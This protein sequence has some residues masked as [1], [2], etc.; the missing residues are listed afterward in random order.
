MN[1]F[2]RRIRPLSDLIAEINEM[3]QPLR[4]L[5]N[6]GASCRSANMAF[7]AHYIRIPGQG[8]CFL[9]K[10][11]EGHSGS[12]S[13]CLGS[14][15]IELT[16]LIGKGIE[17]TDRPRLRKVYAAVLENPL[18]S[19]AER[20]SAL[21]GLSLLNRPLVNNKLITSMRLLIG[22]QL[23]ARRNIINARFDD[24]G[25]IAVPNIEPNAAC[26]VRVRYGQILAMEI[27]H[28]LHV[29]PITSLAPLVLNSTER[30]WRLTTQ[31]T[32]LSGEPCLKVMITAD[33]TLGLSTS[34]LFI[35]AVAKGANPHY[36]I[37]PFNASAEAVLPQLDFEGYDLR[38]ALAPSTSPGPHDPSQTGIVQTTAPEGTAQSIKVTSSDPMLEASKH[39]V[40]EGPRTQ[41][42]K[43]VVGESR[44]LWSREKNHLHS[45][46]VFESRRNRANP[47][48]QAVRV[49]GVDVSDGM[50]LTSLVLL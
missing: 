43:N 2:Q 34:D 40:F 28:Y 31:T 29:F 37:A 12:E 17:I 48:R 3:L 49:R 11:A 16:P 35:V 19:T 5:A 1:L 22:T 6:L 32:V 24:S 47:R 30:D 25:F 39:I 20:A 23:E 27:A 44:F 45:T 8:G 36:H 15:L 42:A 7:N 10:P 46:V 21:Q 9:Q 18:S 38:L 14:L 41:T 33:P 50:Q 13:A 4:F 26:W